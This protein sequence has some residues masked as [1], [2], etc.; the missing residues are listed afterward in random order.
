MDPNIASRFDYKTIS[1]L[2]TRNDMNMTTQWYDEWCKNKDINNY[3]D[4]DEIETQIL[5][6]ILED[7]EADQSH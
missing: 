1:E 6:D 5:Y 4:W 2:V 7:L 3:I